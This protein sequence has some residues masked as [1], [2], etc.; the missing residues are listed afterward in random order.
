MKATQSCSE[1]V[2]KRVCVGA[3]APTHTL[4]SVISTAKALA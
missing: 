3:Y 1:K 2:E 4:F